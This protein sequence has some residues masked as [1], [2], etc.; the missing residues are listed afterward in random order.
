MKDREYRKFLG[1]IRMNIL[2]NVT[3]FII[4]LFIFSMNAHASLYASGALKVGYGSTVTSDTTTVPKTTLAAYSVDASLGLKLFGFILGANG[5][6]SLWKQLTDPSK[7]SNVNTQG[8]LNGIYPMLG[9]EF[10]SIRIIGKL[11]LM[12]SGNYTLD[13]TNSTGQIVKYK[14][15]DT[16]ALQLHW[17]FTP[18]TFWGIEYQSL[19][20][21][22]LNI[23]GAD[24]SLSDAQNL[25]MNSVGILY[26]LFF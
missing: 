8:K 15:A 22:K 26:G 12:I 25:K 18:M 5:E 23:A 14:N 4:S 24:S 16:L 19:K 20:F 17:Q 11:P 9:F 1:I 7:V 21:K 6:Y 13:K 10:G 2:K 3:Y